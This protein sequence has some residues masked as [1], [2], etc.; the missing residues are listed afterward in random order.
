MNIYSVQLFIGTMQQHFY[1]V[2][3]FVLD[4]TLRP[5]RDIGLLNS[6][7]TVKDYGVIGN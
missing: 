4:I 6:V 5:R 3:A 1:F 2:G 7:W